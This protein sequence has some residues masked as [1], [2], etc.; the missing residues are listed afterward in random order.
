M[1][2]KAEEKALMKKIFR[3]TLSEKQVGSILGSP[4]HETLRKHRLRGAP[5]IPSYKCVGYTVYLRSDVADYI[6]KTR[7]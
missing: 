1:D 4:S 6:I 3:T 5:L 7:G 2:L